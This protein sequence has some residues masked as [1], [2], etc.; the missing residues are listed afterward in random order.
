MSAEPI[1]R[2]S[3]ESDRPRTARQILVLVGLSILS[4]FLGWL[5]YREFLFARQ[6]WTWR[7][8]ILIELKIAF[9]VFLLLLLACG[10]A[11]GPVAFLVR[12]CRKI[13]SS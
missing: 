11:V 4:I 6:S 1:T 3:L 10:A 12:R 7:Q 5:V 2:T 8:N 13:F 9:R